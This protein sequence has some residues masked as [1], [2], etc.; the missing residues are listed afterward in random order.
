MR[1]SQGGNFN[2]IIPRG[3]EIGPRAAPGVMHHGFDDTHAKGIADG[4]GETRD[5]NHAVGSVR[6]HRKAPRAKLS[7]QIAR[8]ILAREIAECGFL[9]QL[10]CRRSVHDPV[11]QRHRIAVRHRDPGESR[12]KRHPRGVF[13]NRKHGQRHQPGA[14][15]M[16]CD[17]ADRIGAAQDHAIEGDLVVILECDG[18]KSQH[19]RKQR[20][21]AP[22]AQGRG[23]LLSVRN[24]TCDK[25]GHL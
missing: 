18:F 24:R 13:S 9:F 17:G 23:G 2:A 5:R 15:R 4:L 8:E 11:A 20:L 7:G 1:Q 3:I 10:A 16:L 12:V 19:R 25:N 6:H 22:R 21:M 14:D